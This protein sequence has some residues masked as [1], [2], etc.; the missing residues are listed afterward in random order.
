MNYND[1]PGWITGQTITGVHVEECSQFDRDFIILNIEDELHPDIIIDSRTGDHELHG[2]GGISGL[3]KATQAAQCCGQQQNNV[4]FHVV[5][6]WYCKQLSDL[7]FRLTVV[8]THP[9]GQIKCVEHGLW[10]GQV[11]AHNV[12]SSA[13]SGC[14]DGDR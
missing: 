7:N 12:V 10:I 6:P 2:L 8:K 5:S 11:F 13:V 9:A 1:F 14:G 3:C 4:F